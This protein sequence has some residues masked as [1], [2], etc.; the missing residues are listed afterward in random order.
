MRDANPNALCCAACGVESSS[1]VSFYD[2]IYGAAHTRK[3]N[4]IPGYAGLLPNKEG[5][6]PRL[7]DPDL[8]AAAEAWELGLP[9]ELS[10]PP[11]KGSAQYHPDALKC[12]CCGVESSS[13]ASFVEHLYGRTHSKRAGRPGFA[14]LVPNAA[15][16]LNRVGPFT[17]KLP[18]QS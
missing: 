6:L 8:R 9:T 2:H 11:N 17:H 5:L 10:P 13:E 4:G 1:E 12:A 7:E 3:N 16:P 15:G 14:G 18:Y